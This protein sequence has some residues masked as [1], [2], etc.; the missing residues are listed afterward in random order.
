MRRPGAL[1]AGAAALLAAPRGG[2]QAVAR[3]NGDADVMV[4]GPV[5][6]LMLVLTGRVPPAEGGVAGDRGLLDH[7]PAC[8]RF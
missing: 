2:V 8:T 5:T 4:S 1:G 6:G 3:G 7:W